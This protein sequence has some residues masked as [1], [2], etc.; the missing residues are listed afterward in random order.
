M[1]KL[2]LTHDLGNQLFALFSFMSYTIENSL[3]FSII[4]FHNKNMTGDLVYWKTLLS[5][6]QKY[7][8]R[9][10]LIDRNQYLNDTF[11]ENQ[12]IQY[13]PVPDN[14]ETNSIIDCNFYSYKYFEKHFDEILKFTNIHSKKNKVKEEF[15]YLFD[16]K[17]IAIH[18]CMNDYIEKQDEFYIQKPEYYIHSIKNLEKDL[19]KN[20]ES[21]K[22][23]K[24]LYFCDET[25]NIRVDQFIK[26]IKCITKYEL[27]FVKV[28]DKIDDWKQFLLMS[29][30]SH[31]IISNTKIAWFAAYI[32]NT[33]SNK[34]VYYPNKWFKI[35]H[36]ISD[37]APDNWK[38]VTI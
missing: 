29:C 13:T 23:Y 30:C 7:I 35:D 38:T 24:F 36:D 4:S 31:F 32:S 26:V 37:I 11:Y 2:W 19:I 6:F 25:D 18:F 27:T 21:L 34:I 28:D 8:N 3:K 12:M 33:H 17:C 1:I 20:N 10:V 14:L 5:S 22:D 16:K 9:Y 15:H